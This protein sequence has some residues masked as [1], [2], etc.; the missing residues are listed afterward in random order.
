[1]SNVL[2]KYHMWYNIMVNEHNILTIVHMRIGLRALSYAIIDYFSERV[3]R[4]WET[5][6]RT[7]GWKD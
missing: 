1:M 5:R 2:W 7:T 3:H 4:N 6:R